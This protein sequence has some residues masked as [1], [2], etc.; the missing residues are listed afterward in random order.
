M[1]LESAILLLCLGA[2]CLAQQAPPPAGA[3][4]PAGRVEPAVRHT[5]IEDAGSRIDELRVRGQLRNVT[6]TPKGPWHSYQ[7]LTD[8]GGRDLS[9]GP[10]S[11]RGADGQRVWRVLDF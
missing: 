5:V 1:K 6:V 3:P 11:A 7:I 9:E 2:P 4:A 10:S 8:Q